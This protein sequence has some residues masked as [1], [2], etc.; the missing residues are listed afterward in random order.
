MGKDKTTEE[1]TRRVNT[2]E[3]L[4]YHFNEEEKK[5]LAREMAQNVIK[6]RDLEENKKAVTSQFAS[7]INEAVASSNMAAQK[8]ESGFEMRTIECEEVFDY[9]RNTVE[10]WRLDTGEKVK[11]RTMTQAELQREMFDKKESEHNSVGGH[12]KE[13]SD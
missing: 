3:Y 4:R 7:Q 1:N 5:D 11:D 10:T 13:D 2:T 9:D 8:L 6:T 12:T